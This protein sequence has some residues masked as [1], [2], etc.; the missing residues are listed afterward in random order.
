M[1]TFTTRLALRKPD[2][3]DLVDVETDINDSMDA[4]DAAIGFNRLGAFPASPYTGK[5]VMRS[6]LSDHKFVWNGSA[7]LPASGIPIFATT[8]ARD[9]GFP[10]P[11]EGDNALVTA[12][13]SLYIY[14]GGGWQQTYFYGGIPQA[15]LTRTT[16]QTT[17]DATDAFVAFTSEVIDTLGGHDNVTNNTRYT[18]QAG[19]MYMFC[20][21]I[22]WE[23]S[24]VGVRRLDFRKNGTQFYSGSAYAAG[25]AVRVVSNATRIIELTFGDYVEVSVN[26]TSGGD[27]DID[28]TVNEGC[29]LDVM[30]LGYNA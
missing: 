20:A 29:V 27:L 21:S 18:A 16:A 11:T 10:S 3:T 25:S 26:Q 15:K 28:G 5:P 2:T 24:A 23:N 4:I 12:N 22:P 13:N 14:N 6:D 19:G 17:T 1:A 7:W 9:S 8:A 30:W